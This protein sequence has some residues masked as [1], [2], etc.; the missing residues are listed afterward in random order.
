MKD[1]DVK[2]LLEFGNQ[3][4]LDVF[5]TEEIQS[6]IN[7]HKSMPLFNHLFIYYTFYTLKYVNKIYELCYIFGDEMMRKFQKREKILFFQ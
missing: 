6:V 1:Y 4:V 3:R 2:E 5:T 7:Y